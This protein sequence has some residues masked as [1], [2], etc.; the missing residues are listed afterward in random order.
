MLKHLSISNY[1]LIQKLEMAPAPG[2][3]MITGETGAGKS[4]MLGAVGLLLGNRA[5][6]KV[7][8]D[9]SKKCV[10]EGEFEIAAYGLSTFFEEEELD[11]EPTCIIRREIAPSGKSR[12][13]VNDTPV[14][15]EVLRQLGK[16]LMDIHSQHENLLLGAASYQLGL[17]D[18]FSQSQ[19]EQADYKEAF[20]KFQADKKAFERL[21][22]DALELQ[23][24]ADYNKFQLEEI[25]ALSLEKGEVER[26]EEEQS[27][28]EN[29]EEIKAKINEIF[30]LFEDENYGALNHLSHA[31]QQL[32]D[33]GKYGKSFAQLEERFQSALIELRDI[34]ETLY[35]EDQNVEVD[36]EKLETIREKLSKVYQL[37]KKHGLEH[38]DELIG[39]GE[40]L[41]DKVFQVDNLEENLRELEKDYSHSE[42]T[43]LEKGRVLT[44]KRTS[45]FEAFN[46]EI[47]AILQQLGMENAQIQIR[48]KEVQPESSGMDAV[49]F[50]FSANKGV[51]PQPLGQVASG[52]EFSRLMFAI[53]HIMADKVA[54][55]TLIFD[56][57]DT[58]VS[59][60][61][62][63]QLVNMMKKISA[64]HQVICI[65]HLPQVAAKGDYHY[66]VYK[67]NS[68]EKTF[69]KVK[70]LKQEERLL[71]IA[72]MIAG[73]NPPQSAIKSAKELLAG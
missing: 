66:F 11:N 15:L 55:P 51:S 47:L 40:E 9:E 68:Q 71:E 16:S 27:I 5:D 28:M 12:A 31:G 32:K 67:D 23:K 60:E 29:A 24:E 22:A 6:T 70:L 43:L 13:F 42:K 30:A 38:P 33:L 53:K 44:E 14:R 56:E 50:Y 48:R 20:K 19:K 45:V 7:L 39:I 54:L 64:N 52:G 2:L 65:S 49:E 73:A 36:F 62:A 72:K 10:I 35:Q 58:G 21:K 8:Y 59:G 4:I 57:I 41:A 63:L 69:S 17:I 18:G 25:S 34:Q 1:A 46:K 61:I 37:Q 3:N 26:L